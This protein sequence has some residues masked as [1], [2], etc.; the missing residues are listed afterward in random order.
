MIDG[1]GDWIAESSM[2]RLHVVVLSHSC[3]IVEGHAL[4]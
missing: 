1:L 4:G 2:M 3:F